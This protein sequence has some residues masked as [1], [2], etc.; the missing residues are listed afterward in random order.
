MD[1]LLDNTFFPFGQ[2]RLVFPL[3]HNRNT[4]FPFTRILWRCAQS[5]AVVLGD[6]Y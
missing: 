3:A 4:A 6:G 1:Q 5:D 2:N